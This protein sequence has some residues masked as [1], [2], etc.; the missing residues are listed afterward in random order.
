MFNEAYYLPDFFV[1]RV[2][3]LHSVYLCIVSVYFILLIKKE[4]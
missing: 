1:L 3:I 2:C 4:V